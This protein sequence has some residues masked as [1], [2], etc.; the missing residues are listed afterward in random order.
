MKLE[1][2]KS[3]PSPLKLHEDDHNN[4]DINDWNPQG[5][6]LLG[7]SRITWR[8]SIKENIVRIKPGKCSK[9]WRTRADDGIPSQ[10]TFVPER[11]TGNVK[12][13]LQTFFYSW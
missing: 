11:T 1:L 12:F 5:V 2:A 8:R 13:I 3:G 9:C 7:R 6:R 4:D 10:L